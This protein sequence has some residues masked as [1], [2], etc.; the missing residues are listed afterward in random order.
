M[1]KRSG[2]FGPGLLTFLRELER[3]NERSWFDKNKQRY[4]D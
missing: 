3:N 2:P 4:E 1:A